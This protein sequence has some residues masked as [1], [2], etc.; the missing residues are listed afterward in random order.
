MSRLEG[1]KELGGDRA[2]TGDIKGPKGDS[3]S[4]GAIL[5]KIT[6]LK[7]VQ[8][9]LA[10]LWLEGGEEMHWTSPVLYIP[11]ISLLLLSLSFP[12]FSVSFQ[13]ASEGRSG[14]F[15]LVGVELCRDLKN[16]KLKFSCVE[17]G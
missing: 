13:W 16:D 11:I 12:S 9:P 7:A 4:F 10:G 15:L 2:S 14:A 17:K 5:S 6:G 3:V 1:H 8:A